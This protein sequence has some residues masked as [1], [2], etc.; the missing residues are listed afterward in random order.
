MKI[1][2][3]N[4]CIRQGIKSLFQ[5]RLMTLASIGTISA[6]LF[7]LGI[8]YCIAANVDYMME[9]LEASIGMTVFLDEELTEVERNALQRKIADHIDIETVIYVSPEEAWAR[10]KDELEDGGEELL[11]GLDEDNPLAGSASFEILLKNPDNQGEVIV[12]LEKLAGIRTINH[13]KDTADVLLT[14]NQMVRIISLILIAILALIGILLMTNTIKLTVYI[15]K[16]EINIMK[17]VGATDY[18]IRI[19]FLI[20]GILIGMLGA[21]L[22]L[23]VIW[24]SYQWMIEKIYEEFSIIKNLLTFLGAKEIFIV[25]APLSLLI[26]AGIGMIGSGISVRKHLNV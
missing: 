6:C 24:F 22:P 10:F 9:D 5:N 19:P 14:F 13:A 12:F 23:G 21:I 1:R 25:L 26:G 2:T 17:Y 15:R 7:I 18:F 20:E 11:I 16:N 8:S 4:Y 3:I